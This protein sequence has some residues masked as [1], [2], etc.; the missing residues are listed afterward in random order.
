MEKEAVVAY[1]KVLSGTQGHHTTP[2][3][4][5]AGIRYNLITIRL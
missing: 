4:K 5:M 2:T 3:V 1:F